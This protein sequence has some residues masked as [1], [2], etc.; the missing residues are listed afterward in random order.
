MLVYRN[1]VVL[2]V[3]LLLKTINAFSD[4]PQITYEFSSGNSRY[5][6]KVVEKT[7]EGAKVEEYFCPWCSEKWGMFD[8]K[9][10]ELIYGIDEKISSQKAYISNDGNHIVLINDWPQQP[11]SDSIVLVAFYEKGKL[12]KSYGLSDIFQCGYNVTTSISHFSWLME[13]AKLNYTTN[14]LSLNTLELKYFEFNLK[15]GDL[16]KA[17]KNKKLK[18]NDIL[19]YGNVIKQGN[20]LFR[21]DVCHR[22]YGEV[23]ESGAITFRSKNKHFIDHGAYSVLIRNSDEVIVKGLKEVVYNAGTYKVELEI[24]EGI[25]KVPGFEKVSCHCQ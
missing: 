10:G 6:L 22:V 24:M 15:N 25:L 23:P 14:K 4:S 7:Y 17:R 12:V 2:L 11:V 18:N 19:V 1:K 13:D 20:N 16:I 21:V 9:T 5:R 3:V 8:S